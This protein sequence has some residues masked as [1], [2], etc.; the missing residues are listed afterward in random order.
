MKV[1]VFK[2]IN[3]QLFNFE[4]CLQIAMKQIHFHH[5]AR[6]YKAMDMIH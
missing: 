3:I 1:K 5:A 4:G 2:L 6:T